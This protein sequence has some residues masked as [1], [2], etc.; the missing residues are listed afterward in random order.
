QHHDMG[1]I[2][3]HDSSP[4][5]RMVDLT[6]R[7]GP[8]ALLRVR[9][10]SSCRGALEERVSKHETSR[11]S[12]HA[13]ALDLPFEL[14]AAR[15]LHPRANRL[16]ELLDV[17]AVGFAL[18]DEEVAMHLGDMGAADAQPPAACGID[19]LPGFVAG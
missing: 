3:C 14:D 9:I 19:D 8:S 17:G 5:W 16:A 13:E 7:D 10:S 4:A 18:I 15:R 2:V 12:W 6:L 1:L 11:S